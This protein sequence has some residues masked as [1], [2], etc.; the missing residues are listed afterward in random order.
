VLAEA[1]DSSASR[2]ADMVGDYRDPETVYAFAETVDVVTFDHE[3]VPTDILEEL[4][5]RGHR[6]HPKP[7]ALIFAQDKIRMRERL[8]ELGAPVPLWRAVSTPQELDAFIADAGG[9]AVVKTPRG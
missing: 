7:A 1:E 9:T 8:T 5:R 2:A 3:H 4:E 6:V